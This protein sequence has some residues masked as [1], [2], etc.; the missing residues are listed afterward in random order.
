MTQGCVVVVVGGFTV[1]VVVGAFTVVVVDGGFTVVVVVGAF[2]V[3]VVD[4]GFAVVVVVVGDFTAVEVVTGSVVTVVD[5]VGFVPTGAVVLVVGVL[6][7][8]VTSVGWGSGLPGLPPDDVV[9]FVDVV[10]VEDCGNELGGLAPETAPDGETGAA[11]APGC[12]CVG[13]TA[14]TVVFWELTGWGATAPETATAPSETEPT[15]SATCE[16]ATTALPKLLN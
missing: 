7:V 14:S 8:V 3:V 16:V 2:T 4:G 12:E 1:V 15:T 13:E 9:G 10:D 11:T 5:V 6:V